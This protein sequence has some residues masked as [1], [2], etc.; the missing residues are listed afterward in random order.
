M[1][2]IYISSHCL[3]GY[4]HGYS[5]PSGLFIL[6]VV[7]HTFIM[8]YIS[9]FMITVALHTRYIVRTNVPLPGGAV[10]M[11]HSPRLFCR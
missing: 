5:L 7:S 8:A 2:Y 10:F 3:W 4:L 6:Q 11:P 9:F 1:V